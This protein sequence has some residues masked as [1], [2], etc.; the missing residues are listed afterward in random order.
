[1]AT[2]LTLAVAAAA[3][4]AVLLVALLA[5][6]TRSYRTIGARHTL[7]LVVVGTFLL[8]EN[9]VWLYFYGLDGTF[10]DWYLI[11][12]TVPQIGLFALCGLETIALVV[13]SYL[14]WQ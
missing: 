5:I 2:L 13:L 14:T 12:G 9:G 8:L 6:W 11:I 7:G 4:N 1:M 10:R 3:L